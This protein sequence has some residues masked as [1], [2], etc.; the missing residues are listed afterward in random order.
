ML[1]PGATA[2]SFRAPIR[3]LLA[4]IALF[5]A[6]LATPTWAQQ[7]P[8][9]QVQ[10]SWRLLDYIAVDYR[11]AVREGKIVNPAEYTEMQ[12]FSA[13]VSERLAALPAN[14][15]RSALLADASGLQKAIEAKAPTDDVARR[16]RE[17][18]AK[19][20]AAYPVP[21]APA[22]APDVARGRALYAEHCASCRRRC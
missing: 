10:T 5:C 21:L 8:A 19:L 11:E 2:S 15:A 13:S 1:W 17:L 16:A 9:A 3:A 7:S 20:L 18:A 6:V 14:P 12:E 22:S 4:A